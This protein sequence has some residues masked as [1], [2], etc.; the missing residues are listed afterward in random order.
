MSKTL[1]NA[2]ALLLVAGM[3]FSIGAAPL[4]VSKDAMQRVNDRSPMPSLSMEAQLDLP[5]DPQETTVRRMNFP[6]K[7]DDGLFR[8]QSPTEERRQRA[9]RSATA[10]FRALDDNIDV[11]GQ[12]TYHDAWDDSNWMRFQGFYSLPHTSSSNF[13]LRGLTSNGI[14]W[15]GYY[16]PEAQV[17][18]GISSDLSLSSGGGSYCYN[19]AYD[20]QTWQRITG[21]VLPTFKMC[22]FSV[23]RD[24]SDGKVYGY[25]INDYG[26]GMIWAEGD[27]ETAT[28]DKIADVDYMDRMILMAA[29]EAGQFYGININGELCKI[30]KADGS[31]TVVGSTTIPIM[32]RAGCVINNRNHTML[33]TSFNLDFEN[34][35]LWEIDL[36]TGETTQVAQF[37]GDIQVMNL[38]ID[39]QIAEKA[40]AA[41]L[42]T[43]SA[44][45]GSM[46]A[47]YEVTMPETLFDGTPLS[48]ALDW[49]VAVEGTVVAEGRNM[50]GT[51]ASGNVE[52]TK[53]G[54]TSF[55]A[56]CY[57]ADGESPKALASIFVGKGVPSAPANVNL[58]YADG[59]IKLTWDAVTTSSDGGYV[60]PD[61]VVYTVKSLDGEEHTGITTNAWELEI[62][63]PT[64]RTVYQYSVTAA[65]DGKSSPET[66]SPFI[67][68]GAYPT[69]YDQVLIGL[70]FNVAATHLG[71]SSIDGNGDTCM[72]TFGPNGGASYT[73]SNYRSNQADDWMILPEVY[74]EE[75]QVYEFTAPAYT[76][77]ATSASKPQRLSVYVGQGTAKEDFTTCIVEQTN[78]CA[79]KENAVMLRGV[80]K[81]PATGAYN[82]AILCDTPRNNQWGYN[83]TVYIP[84]THVTSGMSESAP[85]IVTDVVI[86]PEATGL[87][88]ATIAAKTPANNIMGEPL[89]GRVTVDIYRD[90]EKIRTV[91]ANPGA[92]ITTYT[93]N[94]EA[95]GDYE[96]SLVASQNGVAGPAYKKSVFVGPYAA[97][98]PEN[99]QI[100]EA[101]QP[102]Y[103]MVYW[104]PVTQDVNKNTLQ[105]A[106]VTYMVYSLGRDDDGNQVF[107]PMLDAP[108]KTPNAVFMAND[109]PD[110]QKMVEFFVKA[111][112]REA[113]GTYGRSPYI[114]VG[115]P[116]KLPVKYSD[117]AD[118][119]SHVMGTG[120][121]LGG[122]GF[123]FVGDGDGV[124]S[125]DNDDCFFT[126]YSNA[127][128]KSCYLFTGK[129]DLA[130][131]QR[132]ELSFYTWKLDFE[133]TNTIQTHVLADG[134]WKTITPEPDFGYANHSSMQ[135]GCWTKVRYDLSEYKGK[136]VQLRLTAYHRSHLNTPIDNIRIQEVADKDLVAL[137]IEAPAM[138]KADEPFDV[139]VNLTSYGYLPATG[140]TVDLF[141][142]GEL[143]ASR[144]APELEYEGSAIVVFE[145]VISLFDD[146]DT[147]AAFS[148]EIVY[149]GDKDLSNNATAEVTVMREL[150]ELP[151]VTDLSGELVQEGTRL[152]WTG[153][154]TADVQ[155]MQ[156][157]EDFEAADSWATTVDGWTM[158][159]ED[160]EPIIT[161]MSGG[162]KLPFASRSKLPWFVFDDTEWQTKAA[163]LAHSG[164]K[165]LG[166]SSSADCDSDEGYEP[167]SKDWA[168]SPA[169]TGQ[170]QTISFW[171]KSLT[172][173]ERVQV[174]Y[175]T[176]DTDDIKQFT[177][178]K[179]TFGGSTGNQ[180]VPA[181]W[182]KYEVE[183]P[184][185]AMR[186]AIRSYSVD[187]WM[188][189]VD[190][191]T[192][193]PDPLYNAPV[194]VGYDIYRDGVKI[195][196]QPVTG[197]EFVDEGM[198]DGKHT[199]H[200]VGVFDK[201]ISEL[202]NGVT[203][204]RSGLDLIATAGMRV[205]ADGRDIVVTGAA[206]AP[207]SIVTVDGKLLH[208]GIGDLRLNVLP[209]VYLVTVG[210]ETVKLL[211]P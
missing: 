1:K 91:T 45:E 136:Y 171:A 116:Y 55:S 160:K 75:G 3:S 35:G 122:A 28:R 134:V 37:F 95:M 66:V 19:L 175:S 16:D 146:N 82:F 205:Y 54:Q 27:Y 101:Y 201:G 142:D 164:H 149:D 97:K 60:N 153:Y 88:K 190:D 139:T 150:S 63:E 79:Y 87:H 93:D 137:S 77:S 31:H 118:I 13:I 168:I 187:R 176:E 69:P 126:S 92:S 49:K 100:L 167:P 181:S 131:C 2:S 119:N 12:M 179:G 39:A 38:Y 177:Q 20:T 86:T 5:I 211:V 113:E 14:N 110:E 206:S 173:G 174:W 42:L 185:G 24:P 89:T 73:T 78:I 57:N 151:V 52:L 117:L 43:V 196:D 170:A 81:A 107:I 114:A 162:I 8:V 50:P 163:A 133:D 178:I 65:Y 36:E 145:N 128:E 72:W 48:A 193:T 115:N 144:E 121:I 135:P 192:F 84:E 34:S 32:Y 130:D 15:G 165:Y 161:N 166:S 85:A 30:D 4:A 41:P 147:E 40:P 17:Y 61:E 210:T 189:M 21:Q 148:A 29:D 9:L 111:S 83:N 51:T 80:F 182:T 33:A 67:A 140:Y 70:A 10:A 103:V 200:V 152:T 62:G 209:A 132:P 207:V 59:K 141:R 96:Y 108:V 158:V 102:G 191:V 183:L 56:Y 159:D 74:L 76:Q 47:R 71:Y 198:H 204:E 6:V 157:T 155:P 44:P 124:T 184:E 64:L 104:D 23:A 68:L 188:L 138:V 169:L 156:M 11:R 143:V 25:Y 203:L 125:Q 194:L 99:V 129:L 90:G 180:T 7:A 109:T 120:S 197:N 195:N 105:A 123:S 18:H 172:S 154:T 58:A 26:N 202:S 46:T 186:F 53:T 112:N 199:Y 106:N 208:S 98:A 22:A 127:L 94:V